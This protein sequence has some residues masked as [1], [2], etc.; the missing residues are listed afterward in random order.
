MCTAMV[1][2]GVIG[3]VNPDRDLVLRTLKNFG[4]NNPLKIEWVNKNKKKKKVKA[5]DPLA[6]KAIRGALIEHGVPKQIAEMV[7][8]ISFGEEVL[9]PG[10]AVAVTATYKS[11]KVSIFVQEE[12]QKA[13]V[14][15]ALKQ[16]SDKQPVT[17]DWVGD[18]AK[19]SDPLTS[20]AIR[21]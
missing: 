21:D 12:S 2:G 16:F 17:I 3:C 15:R 7:P 4:R 9:K 8:D 11:K 10:Q 1:Q 13:G 20:K 14:L 18:N 5:S 19:A 6:S